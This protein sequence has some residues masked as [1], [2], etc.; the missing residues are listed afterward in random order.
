MKYTAEVI[1]RAPRAEVIEKLD[2]TDNLKHWQPGFKKYTL[3][4]GKPGETGAEAMIEL[5]MGGKD[6]KMKET[7]IYKNLPEA[8]HA[9]YET[10]DVINTQE[11]FFKEIDKETTHWL[12]VNEFRFNSLLMKLVGFLFP[13]SFKKQSLSFMTH[14]KDFVEKG[15]SLADKT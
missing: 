14:F 1:I 2:N 12:A 11:N 9:T 3:L 7:I 6:M 8:I 10:N 5:K 13:G 15:H 4:S